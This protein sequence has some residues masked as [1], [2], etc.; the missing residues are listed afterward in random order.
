[1]LL[2]FG[3]SFK[4]ARFFFIFKTTLEYDA[5]FDIIHQK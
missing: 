2:R 5:T 1:M 3:S 4:T